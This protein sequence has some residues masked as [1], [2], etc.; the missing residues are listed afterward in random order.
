MLVLTRKTGQKL[1]IDNHIVVTVL[2]TRGETV[3]VG[4]DAPRHISIYREE[5]YNEIL[6]TNQQ[7]TTAPAARDLDQIAR[8]VEPGP[9]PDARP[10]G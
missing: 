8:L 10:L 1:I 2:E 5:L 9:R 7:S 3:K 6:Q 4:V